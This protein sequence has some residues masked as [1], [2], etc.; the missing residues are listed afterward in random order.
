MINELVPLGFASLGETAAS[1]ALAFVLGALIGAERQYR[2]R[3]PSLRTP[4]LVALGACQFTDAGLQ[5]GGPEAALRVVANVITGVGFLGAG[6]IMKEGPNIRGLSTAATVWC[7]SGVGACA[8]ANLP[9]QA[10]LLTAF[11]LA[12]NTLLRPLARAI[13]RLPQ[14]EHALEALYELTIAVHPDHAEAARHALDRAVTEAAHT[15]GRIEQHR[16]GPEVVEIVATLAAP[17]ARVEELDAAVARLRALPGALD[18]A[19]V[20]RTGG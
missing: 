3:I 5:M 2:E 20:R 14:R 15:I 11:V 18:A 10:A 12:C 4:V 19:W 7:A 1:L 6:L 13:D 9:A 17:S 8:G 16:R